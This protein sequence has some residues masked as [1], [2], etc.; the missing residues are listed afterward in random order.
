MS[1]CDKIIELLQDYIILTENFASGD[2]FENMFSKYGNHIDNTGFEVGKKI[3]GM[4]K[5]E[6]KDHKDI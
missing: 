2:T 4:I 6:I 1:N 5:K 3:W